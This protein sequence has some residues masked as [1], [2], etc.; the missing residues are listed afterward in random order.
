M[1]THFD[2][3]FD[4]LRALNQQSRRLATSEDAVLVEVLQEFV[5]VTQ[6]VALAHSAPTV[7][8]RANDG[9]TYIVDDGLVTTRKIIVGEMVVR[10]DAR[11]FSSA[12]SSAFG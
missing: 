9:Q 7:T 5:Q 8:V 6:T 12:F 10:V 3:L 11:A 1:T 4:A 2:N